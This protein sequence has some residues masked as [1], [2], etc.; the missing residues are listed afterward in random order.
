[1]QSYILTIT[2]TIQLCDFL[3][4]FQFNYVQNNIHFSMLI[5]NLNSFFF[6]V[7][8]TFYDIGKKLNIRENLKIPLIKFSNSSFVLSSSV[9][10]LML[11]PNL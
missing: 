10:L 9:F 2:I 11:I 8:P 4:I 6:A 3:V 7:A 1:M 5:P